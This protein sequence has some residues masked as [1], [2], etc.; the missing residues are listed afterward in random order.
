MEEVEFEVS[1]FGDAGFEADGNFLAR[2]MSCRRRDF[3][4]QACR[5]FQFYGIGQHLARLIASADFGLE[6]A[7]LRSFAGVKEEF[8]S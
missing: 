6:E 3:N 1:E 7:E 2:L 5:L 8:L 4:L